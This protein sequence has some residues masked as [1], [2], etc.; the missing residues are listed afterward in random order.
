MCV[1]SSGGFG[2]FCLVVLAFSIFANIHNNYSLGLCAEALDNWAIKILRFL[3]TFAGV[4][5]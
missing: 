2:E 1:V 3:W 5:V 4:I